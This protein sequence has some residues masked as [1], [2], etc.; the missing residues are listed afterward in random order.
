MEMNSANDSSLG[1]R[2]HMKRQPTYFSSAGLD[3]LLVLHTA[4]YMYFM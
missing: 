4:L 2:K 3:S 1:I